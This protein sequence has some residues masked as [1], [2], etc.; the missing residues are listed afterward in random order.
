MNAFRTLLVLLGSLALSAHSQQP[1]PAP[2]I[3]EGKSIEELRKIAENLDA[4][5]GSFEF[6]EA[7]YVELDT[8]LSSV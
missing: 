7:A 4:S 5:K 6:V 3:L 8:F 1:K 2:N